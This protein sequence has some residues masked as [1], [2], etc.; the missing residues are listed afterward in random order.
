MEHDPVRELT[1]MIEE[2]QLA[3]NMAINE[4]HRLALIAQRDALTEAKFR[5]RDGRSNPQWLRVHATQ[6]RASRV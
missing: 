1:N 3:A 4:S 2:A 5:L 6:L